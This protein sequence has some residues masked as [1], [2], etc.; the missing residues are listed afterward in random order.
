MVYPEFSR[1][2][3]VQKLAELSQSSAP[4]YDAVVIG[5]G[6]VGAGLLRELAIRGVNALLVEKKDF[7]S[8]T[9]SKSSK[10]VHG[11]LRYLEMFD[12][13]LVFEALSERHWLLKTHPHLV[14]PMEFVLP[15]YKKGEAPVGARSSALLGL[16]LWVYD[17]LSLFRT[18]F[19]H[20][21]HSLDTLKGLFPGV[22]AQGLRG[23]YYYADAMM[24]DDELVLEVLLD[25][26]RRGACALN[27]CAATRVDPRDRD[28]L[29]RIHL[30]T[31]DP[32]VSPPPNE[33]SA[34]ES[35]QVRAREV[36]MCVGPWT[37]EVSGIVAGGAQKK[38]RPSRGVHLVLDWA[39]LPV[40]RCL[41]MYAPDGRIIFAIPR[42]D[43]GDEAAVTIVGTTDAPEHG[44]IDQVEATSDDV[45]YLFGVLK[46]YFPNSKLA[47]SDVLMTYAGVRPLIDD[48]AENEAKTSREHEIWKNEQ[49]V[50]FMAGGKYTTFRKISEEIADFAFPRSKSDA[51]ESRQPLSTPDDYAKRFSGAPLWGRFT[52]GW[53]EWKLKHHAPLCL[54][55]VV[56]RRLPL[57]MHGQKIPKD[58]IERI[59]SISAKTWNQT[60]M[61]GQANQTR[62]HIARAFQW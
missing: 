58:V 45:E 20:G 54:D 26:V 10:L 57:W 44:A 42:K 18:P 30:E 16:G 47:K 48:G 11:G 28:G 35:L 41:V 49:G 56:F 40:E 37:E 23:G 1:A 13:G 22:R 53:V 39:R 55:D 59:Q 61:S 8:G 2:T 17:A 5:G 15:I 50:V 43:L 12:F 21:R 6:I 7:A 19:F 27:Y 38:L 51:K 31:C 33:Q 34:S 4:V 46:E 24:L 29:Y 32:A 60:S 52:E 9:S 14:S 36:I 62:E 3:R 25:S